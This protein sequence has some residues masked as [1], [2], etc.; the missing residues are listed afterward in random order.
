MI[1]ARASCPQSPWSGKSTL[2][3][4]RAEVRYEK[5]LLDAGHGNSRIQEG[6]SPENQLPR[7]LL[8]RCL[9]DGCLRTCHYFP[10]DGEYEGEYG[11][12]YSSAPHFTSERH[13][14]APGSPRAGILHTPEAGVYQPG[15]TLPG[16]YVKSK[17][18]V[19]ATS[20]TR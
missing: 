16:A 10:P 18:A 3:C 8:G 1:S 7:S 4:L 12:T 6:R 19:L 17:A 11:E 5:I 2:E 15:P 9:L 14:P 20:S 13:P